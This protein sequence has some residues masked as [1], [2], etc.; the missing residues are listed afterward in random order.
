M[1]PDELSFYETLP[2]EIMIYRGIS[3]RGSIKA[4]S[5][6]LD[7]HKAE[8]FSQRFGKKSRVYRAKIRREDVLAYFA[9]RGEY[10]VVVDYRKLYAI[11]KY[12]D[13]K[14]DDK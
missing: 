9:G 10:E 2:D 5:W 14:M 11:E 8:W 3:K 13:K 6:T 1:E 4:L 12:N 7:M